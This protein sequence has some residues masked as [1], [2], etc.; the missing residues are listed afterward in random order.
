MIWDFFSQFWNLITEVGEYPIEFFQNIG[1]AVAGAI[2]SFFDVIF[3]SINDIFVFIGWLGY[4]LKTIFLSLLSPINYIINVLRFFFA[5]AFSTPAEP[6]IT[7][8]FS[9]EILDV[10]NTIPHWEILASIL[11]AIIILVFGISMLKLL[12][13]T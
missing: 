2:G 10:F 3:H 5:T 6:E 1:I 7:Y 12:L 8:T 11:G 4:S 9:E 13:R